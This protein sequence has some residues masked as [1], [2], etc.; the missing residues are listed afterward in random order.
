MKQKVLTEKQSEIISRL[1]EVLKE[2]Q[3]NDIAFV[4][5]EDDCTLTAYNAENVNIPYCG[6]Y[7]E[8]E[9]DEKMNWDISHVV[10]NFVADYFNTGF[11]DFYLNFD[12]K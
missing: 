4:F 7:S 10:G 5:D 1:E 8:S 9:N 11:D 6:R 3:E 2:A 12:K